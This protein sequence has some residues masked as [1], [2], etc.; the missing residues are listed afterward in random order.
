MISGS[1]WA[2]NAPITRTAKSNLTVRRGAVLRGCDGVKR[3]FIRVCYEYGDL[4]K[5]DLK[6]FALGLHVFFRVY[7]I[8]VD[9]VLWVL[10]E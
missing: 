6:P 9:N 7:R 1:E 8:T 4:L 3:D 2:G 10:V 5:P